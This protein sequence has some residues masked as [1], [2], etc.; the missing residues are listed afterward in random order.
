[1]LSRRLAIF[2]S[3]NSISPAILAIE[4]V[5]LAILF[6]NDEVIVKY[7]VIISGIVVGT[8]VVLSK[9]A[10]LKFA[11]KKVVFL[12]SLLIAFKYVSNALLLDLIVISGNVYN[13]FILDT[14]VSILK[15][16]YN[17]SLLATFSYGISSHLPVSLLYI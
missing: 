15:Y 10:S 14:N 1:M 5:L 2:L 4:T 13:L 7:S 8:L 6:N 17:A 3:N 11:V 9:D 12:N 16:S